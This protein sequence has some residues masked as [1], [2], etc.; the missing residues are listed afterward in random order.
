MLFRCA[1]CGWM[2]D[3]TDRACGMCA[4]P[5]T[6]PANPASPGAWNPPPPPATYGYPASPPPVPPPPPGP[7]HG[8]PY[9]LACSKCGWMNDPDERL[10]SMCAHPVPVHAP[11][12]PSPA[13]WN[14]P[15]P[16]ATYGRLPPPP[17][18]VPAPAPPPSPWALPGNPSPRTAASL[19]LE[20]GG[21]LVSSHQVTASC[22]SPSHCVL[23]WS[24]RATIQLIS[25]RLSVNTSEE[26]LPPCFCPG[27]VQLVLSSAKGELKLGLHVNG[28][29]RIHGWGVCLCLA[30]PHAL[31]E[32]LASK[33]MTGPWDRLHGRY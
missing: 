7:R 11:P 33:G 4:H 15:P 1:R 23:A 24:D 3:A 2:N 12:P 14:P 26:P 19:A 5:M 20:L 30:H 29:V 25:D 31:I 9:R 8:P 16:P 17:P 6:A 13:A 32:W 18:W 21:Y 22:S 10:C 28:T 27:E